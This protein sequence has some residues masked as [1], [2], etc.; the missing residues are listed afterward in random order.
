MI[1]PHICHLQAYIGK[2]NNTSDL[3]ET[4]VGTC[5]GAGVQLLV[6][7]GT[8][9]VLADIIRSVCRTCNHRKSPAPPD[10]LSELQIALCACPTGQG[11]G[12]G[13]LHPALMPSS[14]HSDCIKQAE[15]SDSLRCLGNCGCPSRHPASK[16]ACTQKQHVRAQKKN[17]SAHARGFTC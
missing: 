16:T 5:H 10:L 2:I 7:W 13:I 9:V 4:S 15:T 8:C 11:I 1:R 17:R 12:Q 3:F 6:R 14:A